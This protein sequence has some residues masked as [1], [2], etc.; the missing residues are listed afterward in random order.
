MALP[1][2][3]APPVIQHRAPANLF[4]SP[5]D[6]TSGLPAVTNN[7]GWHTGHHSVLRNIV[8]HDCSRPYDGMRSDI[9]TRQYAC[10]HSDIGSESDRHWFHYQVSADNRIAKG[11]PCVGRAEHPRSRTPADIVLQR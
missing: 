4:I 8:G 7:P 10:V 2:K 1:T 5:P 11:Q 6:S 9:Q 3:P